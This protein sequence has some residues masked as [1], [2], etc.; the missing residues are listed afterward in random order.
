MIDIIRLSLLLL[1]VAGVARATTPTLSNVSA[2]QRAG[3]KCVEIAFDVAS[4]TTNRVTVS[5]TVSNATGVLNATHFSGDVGPGV[6]TGTAR[7]IVWDGGADQNGQV[8][9]SLQVCL[10]ASDG[11][12]SSG[13]PPGMVSIPAG[14]FSMG[15]ASF[16]PIHPVTLSAFY[17]DRTEVTKDMWDGVRTWALTNGYTLSSASGKAAN[18]PVQSMDWHNAVRWCNARSAREGLTPCYTNKNGTLFKTGNFAGGCNWS[19]NG[20]RLPTEAEWEYAARGTGTTNRFPWID[21]NEIQHTRANY[22]SYAGT[23]YDTSLTRGYNPAYTN[24]AM[25][26]T[27]PAGAFSA[28][29]YG[30]QDMAGNVFEWC[31][32]YYKSP[33]LTTPSLNP[34]GP[35]TGSGHIIRGGSWGTVGNYAAYICTVDYRNYNSSDG[36]S[37]IIGFRCARSAPASG[38]SLADGTGG[39]LASDPVASGPFTADFRDYTLTVASACGTPAPATGSLSYA[40]AT[41]VTGTAP[42]VFSAGG[43]NWTCAGWTGTGSVPLSGATTNTGPMVL[44]NQQSSLTWQWSVSAFAPAIAVQPQSRTNSCA[45]T[46]VFS[47]VATGLPCVV[48]QWLC[49]GTNLVNGDRISGAQSP[50]LEVANTRLADDGSRY[51]VVVSNALGCV[52]SQAAVLTAST[53][54]SPEEMADADCD[55]MAAWQ[56]F[57]AGTSPSNSASV[58]SCGLALL[59]GVPRV[60]WTP[61]LGATRVYAVEGRT[62]LTAG[63]WGPTNSSSRF[64]RV[65][66]SMP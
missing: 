9:S 61:D 26:Y 50:A 15:S 6:A 58:F 10:T 28:N 35:A 39:P 19:A 54:Y 20:Y 23:P 4:T 47:V 63:A 8:L 56:E 62:N 18:H 48:Y 57:I 38:A 49:N 60:T 16:T 12:G 55:G 17:L 59:G 7:Q 3:S 5:V 21:C 66:V 13:T 14:T 25:P 2:S 43:T 1:G 27:S 53:T 44:T 64:Y 40:W 31:W 22:W 45:F 65:R 24:G 34:R 11:S 37:N 29:A 42:R 36:L 52:T 46:A 32:D 30:L 51:T 41:T 33:Y